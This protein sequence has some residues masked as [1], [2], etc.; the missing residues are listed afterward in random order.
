M[1]DRKKGYILILAAAILFSTTEVVLKLTTSVFAPMQ[2]L[3][4]RVTAAAI[5]L[6]PF[7]LAEYKKK[8]IK[9]DKSDLKI[10]LL[11]GT[12]S[13]LIHLLFLQLSTTIEDASAVAIIYSGNCIFAIFA[14]HFILGEKLRKNNI[15][16]AAIALFG[17]L[18][19]LNPFKLEMTKIGF[20]FVMI[21]TIAH[22]FY[23]SI[24]KLRVKKFGGII[25][26][27]T[28]FFVGGLELLIILLLGKTGIFGHS[29]FGYVP[30]F[31]G[32]SLKNIWVIIYCGPILCGLGFIMMNKIVEL[33]SATEVAF[34]YFLKPIIATIFAVIFLNEYISINRTIGIILF[35]IASIIAMK[36]RPQT[37]S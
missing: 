9:I 8:N 4:L 15:I 27:F 22:S 14:A 18:F 19:I 12:V 5:F 23:G 35:L 29:L 10:F 1:S 25:I 37:R 28:S 16:A 7:A 26:S 3:F 32:I 31:S 17:I 6:F 24:S 20:T 2:Y 30:I 21:A 11:G 13:V 33:T 34:I 36:K